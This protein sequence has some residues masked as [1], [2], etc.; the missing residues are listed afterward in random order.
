[1]RVLF[2]AICALVALSSSVA[3][4]ATSAEDVVKA[5]TQQVIERLQEEK[6]GRAS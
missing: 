2:S 5:T 6:Q 4:A 1:M 3:V